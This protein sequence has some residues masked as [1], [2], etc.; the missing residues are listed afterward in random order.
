M[1]PVEFLKAAD[2]LLSDESKWTRRAY[3]RDKGHHECR[4]KD[5]NAYSF[6]ILGAMWKQD[7]YGEDYDNA[8]T[9]VSYFAVAN[10]IEN[11]QIP[12][13]ND[14][15]KRSFKDVKAAYRNAIEYAEKAE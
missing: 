10:G 11:N 5:D 1:K 7:P 2:K 12:Q 15:P 9:A 13:W 3:A 8:V 4:I 14:D 6:C